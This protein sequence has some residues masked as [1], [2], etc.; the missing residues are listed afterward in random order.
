MT[1]LNLFRDAFAK[2]GTVRGSAKLLNWTRKKARYWKDRLDELSTETAETLVDEEEKVVEFRAQRIISLEDLLENAKVDLSKWQVTNYIVNSWET[3]C[4]GQPVPLFQVKANLRLKF[5]NLSPAEHKQIQYTPNCPGERPAGDFVL[6]VPDT[7][8]GFSIDRRTNTYTPMHDTQAWKCVVEYAKTTKPTHVV[9]L[10]DHLDLA[11]W[12]TKYTRG[13]EHSFTTQQ[14][15]QA[16]YDD[17]HALREAV[18]QDCEIHYLEGNHEARLQKILQE[19]LP[20]AC[21]IS[22]ANSVQ[23]LLSVPNILCLDK[24]NIQYHGP[25]GQASGDF[26]LWGEVLFTHG[27]RV[28]SKGGGS[29]NAVISD[30]NYSTVFGHVHRSEIAFR[31]IHGPS[32]SNELFAMTPGTLS[33]TDGAVPPGGKPDWQQGCAVIWRDKSNR[34]RPRL[35]RL[36]DGVIW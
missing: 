19:K 35:L 21:D 6:I 5:C 18:G 9:L 34:I 2:C 1:E 23:P 7:Q 15:I 25:Y 36:L 13:P 33:R 4:D 31:T 12:S 11:E 26:W 16:L 28:K 27:S 8:H 10:G 24:L 30:A 14:A 22:A 17:L 29:V 20:Q 32:S 3:T